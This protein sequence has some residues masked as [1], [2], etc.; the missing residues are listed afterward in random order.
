MLCNTDLSSAQKTSTLTD[1][2]NSALKRD[3][4]NKKP[5]P[6][7][8]PLFQDPPP[9]VCNKVR[10]NKNTTTES[11]HFQTQGRTQVAVKPQCQCHMAF[12]QCSSCSPHLEVDSTQAAKSV[13]LDSV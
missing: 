9:P 6:A 13:S 5:G 10:A 11:H 8:E 7:M 2:V 12:Q 1:H 3:V 4:Q